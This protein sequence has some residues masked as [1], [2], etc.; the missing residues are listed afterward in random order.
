MDLMTCTFRFHRRTYRTMHHLTLMRLKMGVAFFSCLR[1][2]LNSRMRALS[3]FSAFHAFW[4]MRAMR[5]ST[6]FLSRFSFMSRMR[7]SSS[8][9]R[10][11][12]FLVRR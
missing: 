4:M 10:R 3:F 6:R 12:S 7:F 5:S 1:R 11:S 2:V 9:F 8:R